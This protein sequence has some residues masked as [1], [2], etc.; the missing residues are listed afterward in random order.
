MSLTI[1]YSSNALFRATIKTLV[2]GLSSLA[3]IVCAS[4]GYGLLKLLFSAISAGETIRIAEGLTHSGI[5]RP[6][7]TRRPFAHLL[8]RGGCEAPS[9]APAQ[10]SGASLTEGLVVSHT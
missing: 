8:S 5:T 6:C 1:L 9:R 7:V 4:V 2:F 10:T 3:A